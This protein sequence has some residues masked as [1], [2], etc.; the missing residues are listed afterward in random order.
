M[1]S[2]LNNAR[3]GSFSYL[4]AITY[5]FSDWVVP[6]TRK[7][8][9]LQRCRHGPR[10]LLPEGGE[11]PGASCSALANQAAAR[12]R[13]HWPPPPAPAPKIT[14]RGFF[15]SPNPAS[16]RGENCEAEPT[17]RKIERER[18]REEGG[19]G[20]GERRCAA[21]PPRLRSPSSLPSPAQPPRGRRPR[22]RARGGA[23]RRSSTPSDPAA[24]SS[25]SSRPRL[26]R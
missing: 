15:L 10:C 12:T 1:F 24:P 23:R 25:G 9:P 22:A 11:P 14:S 13:P 6:E 8:M 3:S 16:T 20:E 19:E 4:L 21:P 2:E 18:E 26:S 17:E 5:F 7:R